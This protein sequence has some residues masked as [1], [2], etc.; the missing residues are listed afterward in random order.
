MYL[1]VHFDPLTS[2]MPVLLLCTTGWDEWPCYRKKA[3]VLKTRAHAIKGI[4]GFL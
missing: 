2:Q 3:D 1:Q 4:Q